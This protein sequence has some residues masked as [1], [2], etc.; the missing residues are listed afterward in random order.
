MFEITLLFTLDDA[1]MVLESAGL[2]V[3]LIDIDREFSRYHNDTYTEK[4]PTWC[5]YNPNTQKPEPI[6]II[7]RKYLE[8]RKKELFLRS[9]NKIEIYN[10]FSKK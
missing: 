6:D 5:V 9:E 10:L 4:V 3:E 1:R 8:L 7:F 2:K